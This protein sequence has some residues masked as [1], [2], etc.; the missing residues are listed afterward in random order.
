MKAGTNSKYIKVHTATRWKIRHSLMLLWFADLMHVIEEVTIH[1]PNVSTLLS[2]AFIRGDLNA[3]TRG[4]FGGSRT[5]NTISS[6]P[7]PE[8]T[9]H[10]TTR[11]VVIAQNHKKVYECKLP[12]KSPVVLHYKGEVV[13]S[14]SD[15][16][17]LVQ[18]CRAE[19]CLSDAAHTVEG[20]SLGSLVGRWVDS[21]R[22]RLSY[23]ALQI[24]L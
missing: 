20:G 11:V 15:L 23:S 10:V 6:I 1:R 12:L 5:L 7:T 19:A 22:G 18:G 16:L 2:S 24:L 4:P 9:I 21:V 8:K 13:H 14:A 3:A 17:C